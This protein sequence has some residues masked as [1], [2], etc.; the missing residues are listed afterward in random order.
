MLESIPEETEE[1]LSRIFFEQE[2]DHSLG[3]T[4]RLGQTWREV[5]IMVLE[6]L[7][8]VRAV[9]LPRMGKKKRISL[10]RM[11]RWLGQGLGQS[12]TTW[13]KKPSSEEREKLI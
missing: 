4:S 13:G 12:S 7:R 2:V 3:W 9:R 6:K 8:T 5:E 10:P 11:P 1:E